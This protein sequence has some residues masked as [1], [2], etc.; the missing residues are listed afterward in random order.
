MSPSTAAIRLHGVTKHYEGEGSSVPALTDV[1]L[2]IGRGEFVAI[3]GP[4]GCG[5]STL[6][7]IIGAMDRPTRGEVWLGDLPLHTYDE[8][9]V[10][11]VRRSP[12]GFVFQFFYLLPTFTVE[13]NVGLPLLLAG[14]NH[15]GQKIRALLE[16]V[17]LAHRSKAMPQQLS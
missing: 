2:D 5:K 16:T 3:M 12:V 17:G 14:R 1:S 9:A 8:E 10:T 7:H 4:S 6:L 11:R 13:E 15:A